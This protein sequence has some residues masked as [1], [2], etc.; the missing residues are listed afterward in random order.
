MVAAL[1]V[2]LIAGV[3]SANSACAHDPRFACSPRAASDSIDIPDPT[4][5]WAYYGRLAPRTEDHYRFTMRDAARIPV[6]VLVDVRDGAN[7]ARPVVTILDE[8]AKIVA[9][10]DL[11]DPVT[12]V[13]PF[14][15]VTYIS[16]KDRLVTLERGAYT[17]LV[18][19]QGATA[20]QRYTVAI[21]SAERFSIFEIPYVAGAIYRI[22]NRKF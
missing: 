17:M 3:F 14:S 16:S 8:H 19:M 5:S 12:L 1:A 6:S 4:K 22:H 18:A 21:G 10:V 13:E 7:P 11:S 15:R 20:E 2:V 9:R